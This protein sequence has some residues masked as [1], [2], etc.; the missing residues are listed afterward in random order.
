M[1]ASKESI[2]KMWLHVHQHPG[3]SRPQQARNDR[4]VSFFGADASDAPQAPV[5]P[6]VLSGR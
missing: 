3:N 1:T 4:K 6:T 2:Q 5:D